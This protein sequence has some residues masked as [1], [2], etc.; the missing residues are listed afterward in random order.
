MRGSMGR[1]KKI[2][3]GIIPDIGGDAAFNIFAFILFDGA[4]GIFLDVFDVRDIIGVVDGDSAVIDYRIAKFDT[5]ADA[6]LVVGGKAVAPIIGRYAG[7]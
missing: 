6:V 7:S 4:G 5:S 2:V 3:P 1:M